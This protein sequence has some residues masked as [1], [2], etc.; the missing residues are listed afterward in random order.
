MKKTYLLLLLALVHILKASAFYQVEIDGLYYS[1]YDNTCSVVSKD[2]APYKM[3]SHITIPQTIEY[4]G[5]TYTV[6]SIGGQAFRDCTNLTSIELPNTITKLW[7]GA[8]EG[9]TNLKTINLPSGVQSIGNLA[10]SGCI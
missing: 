5:A 1:G 6:T 4:Y 7:A 2:G 10:F 8:F 9:C 3:W